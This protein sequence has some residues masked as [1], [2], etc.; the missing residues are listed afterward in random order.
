MRKTLLYFK[1]CVLSSLTFSYKFKYELVV[2]W[3]FKMHKETLKKNLMKLEMH[4]EET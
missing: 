3:Q 4:R 1:K 2:K